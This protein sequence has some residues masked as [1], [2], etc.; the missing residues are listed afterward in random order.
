LRCTTS[1]TRKGKPMSGPHDIGIE[2]E[3]KDAEA[4]KAR[5][6]RDATNGDKAHNA[7]ADG[8]CWTIDHNVSTFKELRSMPDTIVKKMQDAGMGC[9]GITIPL[10]GGRSV[11]ATGM[12]GVMGV[13]ICAL[14]YALL[15]VH[16]VI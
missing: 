9:G 1:R 10:P 5:I 13:V 7:L 15:K 6:M 4:I 11:K 2:L 12:A 3:E 16:Q 14:V 8:L